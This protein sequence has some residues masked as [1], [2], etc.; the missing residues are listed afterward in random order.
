MYRHSV[1]FHENVYHDRLATVLATLLRPIKRRPIPG[2]QGGRRRGVYTRS[3]VFHIQK[4]KGKSWLFWTIADNNSFILAASGRYSITLSALAN[5]L[6]GIVNPICF[7][8]LRLITNSNLLGR[9]T[10]RSPGFAPL[11]ILST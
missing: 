11:R 10:G 7:A 9:S 2:A 6:G 8:A 4:Q 1:T 3:C 5:T